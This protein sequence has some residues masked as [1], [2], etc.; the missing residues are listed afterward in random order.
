MAFLL[1][2]SGERMCIKYHTQCN[3]DAVKKN[4]FETDIKSKI[5]NIKK[6]IQKEYKSDT[7]QALKLKEATKN[8]VINVE[9]ISRKRC[10]ATTKFEYV[11]GGVDAVSMDSSSSEERKIDKSIQDFL[12]LHSKKNPKNRYYNK[13]Q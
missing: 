9:Y 3:L 2:F 8:I 12:A 10:W 7:G 13:K 5:N 6:Y 1:F 11:I 4:S